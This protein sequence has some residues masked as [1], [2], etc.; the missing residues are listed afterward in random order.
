MLANAVH[1]ARSDWLGARLIH[2]HSVVEGLA[3]WRVAR[4][5]G[6]PL[7]LTFNG[8]DMNVWPDAH[9]ERRADLRRAVSEAAAVFAVSGALV[10][11]I[12]DV[13]SVTAIRLPFGSDL[14]S[15]EA[16][17]MP[18]DL[19]RQRLGLPNDRF[20]ALFV[21]HLLPAKG[22]RAFVDAVAGLGD[23]YLA[24]LLGAG[25]EAGYGSDGPGGRIQ[26][27][28]ERPHDHVVQFMSAADALVLPS[29]REGLPNVIVEAGA[30]GLPVIGS[31]VGGIPEL[32]GDDRG[33]LLPDA[34]AASI[35]AALVDMAAD[36]EGARRRARR[37]RELVVSEY[38]VDRN[39]ARLI[40]V[41]RDVERVGRR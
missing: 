32:L 1:R 5:S 37:L 16:A 8:S 26:Y 18:R 9:P 14:S 29:A 31:N 30:L 36:P 41:Y 10:E 21:G 22:V 13:T 7:V 38:D 11:R 2:G 3:A 34:T 28:G 15:M 12:R 17:S 33:R 39:T 40:D 27:V 19:A 4:L 20:V 25:P 6:L 24:I 35:G 23:P